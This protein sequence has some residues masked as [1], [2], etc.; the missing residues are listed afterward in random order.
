MSVEHI[1]VEHGF[2]PE[3]NTILALKPGRLFQATCD[4]DDRFKY[5]VR[6]LRDSDPSNL[7]HVYAVVAGELL[8]GGYLYGR[9]V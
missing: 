7:I 4:S 3:S 9:V 6:Y 5:G 2:L 1:D 8:D